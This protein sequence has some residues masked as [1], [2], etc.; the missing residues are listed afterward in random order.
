MTTDLHLVRSINNLAPVSVSQGTN[1][2][3]AVTCNALQGILTLQSASTAK[4]ASDTFKLNNTF[5]TSNTLGIDVY[6][7]SYAGTWVTNGQVNIVATDLA[8]GSCQIRINNVDPT[9]ALSGVIV[10][11]FALRGS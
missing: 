11:G 10:M 4:S 1:I 3:T 7:R 2:S 6:I 5:I 8:V 9:S